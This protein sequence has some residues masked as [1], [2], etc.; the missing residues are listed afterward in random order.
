[1]TLEEYVEKL[2]KFMKRHPDLKDAPVIFAQDDEG[3]S[4]DTV[5]YPP[6]MY[7][8]NDLEFWKDKPTSKFCVCVN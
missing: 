2:N 4:Y 5:K 6:C 1:M 8:T 3:N 7:N